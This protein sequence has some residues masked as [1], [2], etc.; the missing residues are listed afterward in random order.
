M[1]TPTVFHVPLD[2][3]SE[4]ERPRGIGWNQ[5]AS[6]YALGAGLTD[7][8]TD[9]RWAELVVEAFLATP[10]AD[11]QL[12]E[13]THWIASA[14]AAWLRAIDRGTAG[15]GMMQRGLAP[16]ASFI[17]LGMQP[18]QTNHS[19]TAP[20]GWQWWAMAAGECCLFQLRPDQSSGPLWGLGG[21]PRYGDGP[22]S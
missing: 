8:A 13:P 6:R 19:P 21:T 20:V 10:P 3:R 2:S 9:Q 16:A 15:A 14:Q 12:Q 18:A 22:S 4:R 7:A 17:G 11:D 5:A 1:N